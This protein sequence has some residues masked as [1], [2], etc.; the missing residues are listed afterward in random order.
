M[1]GTPIQNSLFDLGSLV[2]FLRVPLLEDPAVFRKHVIGKRTQGIFMRKPNAAN[3]ERLV[4]AVCLRRSSAIL[5]PS[6]GAPVPVQLR[7]DLARWERRAYGRLAQSCRR[8]IDAVVRNKRTKRGNNTILTALLKLRLF[9]NNGPLTTEQHDDD[10]GGD[11]GLAEGEGDFVHS[12]H[13]DEVISLL[14]QSG[15]ATCATCGADLDSFD[16]VQ[17]GAAARASGARGTKPPK[18]DLSRL[19]LKCQDC[20]KETK[21]SAVEAE[22]H[23]AGHRDAGP[24]PTAAPPGDTTLYP[25]K[26]QALLADLQEH[27]SQD[28][29]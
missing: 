2:K 1:T 11:Q 20:T 23:S 21:K 15:D 27:Q 17:D 14:Q 5:L 4:C 6:V 28:K 12:L 24:G 8:A 25:S 16:R 9:C 22:V 18:T 26:L 29:R 3:L 13:A 19:R 7:P 10:G